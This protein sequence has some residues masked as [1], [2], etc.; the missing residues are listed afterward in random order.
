MN[1]ARCAERVC[2]DTELLV[3]DTNEL[4]K[5]AGHDLR[6]KASDAKERLAESLES[7][8]G[9]C[10][11]AQRQMRRLADQADD[12]VHERP[13]PAMGI[14]FALGVLGALLIRRR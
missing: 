7:A 10:L 12:M 9:E 5:A 2:K 8:K 11:Q 13:Y 3:Q 14:A 6:A 4:L 1:T